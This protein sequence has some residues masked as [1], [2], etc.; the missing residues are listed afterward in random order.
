[1]DYTDISVEEVWYL[2]SD[3]SNGIQIP[4]DVRTV[5]EWTGERIDTPFPEFPRHFEVADISDSEGY[6]EFVDLYD[7]KDIIVYCK[8]GGRSASAANILIANGFNGTV[9]NMLGGITAWKS[10]GYPT[11][12]GNT[13][14]LSP[15]KPIGESVCNINQACNFSAQT[16]DPDDDPIRYGWDWNADGFVDEWSPYVPSGQ[17]NT[18]S[19]LWLMM[20]TYDIAVLAQ[21]NVGSQSSFSTKLTITINSPPSAPE[22]T[23]PEAGKAGREYDYEIVSEDI[24]GDEL[25]Y[26]IEWGDDMVTGWTRRLP[27]GEALQISHT[28]EEKNTY[29]IRVQAKDQY[30]AKSEWSN[31]EIS[32]PKTHSK[33]IILRLFAMYPKLE[34]LFNFLN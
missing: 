33:G 17:T 23:G 26:Y 25:S 11:K 6:Q 2:L 22:I 13:N 7:G 30:D 12:T 32:M 10:A 29:T 20:G 24:D 1:V 14:P 18:L 3:T 31:L 16:T 4:V 27:S 28:W 5:M 8:S 9:Y 21:D 19:H 15:D 34:C